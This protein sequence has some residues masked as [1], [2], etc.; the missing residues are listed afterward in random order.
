MKENVRND[1]KRK[2]VPEVTTELY[3]DTIMVPRVISNA[4]GI[5]IHGKRI[6][7]LIFTT[8][9]SIIMNTNA[10]AV[11]AVYPFTPQPA[12]FSSIISVSQKPIFAGVGG[13]TTGGHRCSQ[14][15]LFAEA[16]GAL[17][18]V[19]NA[20]TTMDTLKKLRE[21]VICPIVFTIVS[22]YMDIEER[23]HYGANI[24]NVSGGKNTANIVRTI[25]KK[26]EYVP[27]I[28]TGGPTNETVQEVIDAGANAVSYTP[29][30][31]GDLFRK[32][33]EKYRNNAKEKYNDSHEFI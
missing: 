3:A 23:L 4:S 29:P 27:I 1:Q 30:S 17:A 10:D 18:V 20:P 21:T 19:L 5:R 6:K 16:H 12:I 2:F 26:Y 33:M 7:S 8:D 11:L 13:G 9:I 22:E 28:A 24:L 15:G 25:R 14:M 32:K 31:N